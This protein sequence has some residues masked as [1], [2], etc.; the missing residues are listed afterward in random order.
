MREGILSPLPVAGHPKTARDTCADHRRGAGGGRPAALSQPLDIMPKDIRPQ[1]RGRGAGV[2][3]RGR[4]NKRRDDGQLASYTC[5]LAVRQ[6]RQHPLPCSPKP[7]TQHDKK[8]VPVLSARPPHPEEKPSHCPVASGP[9]GPTPRRAV[10]T[11][12]VSCCPGAPQSWAKGRPDG[13]M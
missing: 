13:Q 7:G 10:N 5:M 8:H 1:P 11:R 12:R 6:W 3:T 9:W 4:P 2:P